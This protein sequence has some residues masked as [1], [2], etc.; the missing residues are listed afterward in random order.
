MR[1]FFFPLVLLL[2]LGNNGFATHFAGGDCY[3]DYVSATP[4]DNTRAR[5]AVH[6][7]FYRDIQGAA[8]NATSITAGMYDASPTS[9]AGVLE[10][11]RTV[12]QYS[13]QFLNQYSPGCF[14][15][16]P[17]GYERVE[18]IDTVDLLTT[19]GYFFSTSN[20][21]RNG[22]QIQ[23]ISQ[24]GPFSIVLSTYVPPR[25]SFDNNSPR[26][27][28]IPVPYACVGK[29]YVFNHDGFDPDGDSL[30]FNIVWPYGQG[31]TYRATGNVGEGGIPN[32]NVTT[33][34]LAQRVHFPTR[35][36][37]PGNNTG[38]SGYYTPVTYQG[39]Y[40]FPSNQVPA[41]LPDTLKMNGST[42][43]FSF[44]PTNQGGFV[45][46]I[47]CLE[48]RV[49]RINNVT[50]YLGSTRRDL[51]FFFDASCTGNT[52]PQIFV[53]D[54][55]TLN[56]GDSLILDANAIDFNPAKN[57]VTMGVTGDIIGTGIG[58]ATYTSTS[59]IGQATLSLRW[60]A[61]CSY[62]RTSPYILIITSNDSLCATTQKS[63]YI[64]VLPEDIISKPTNLIVIQN[65]TNIL[66]SWKNNY[67][68]GI[69]FSCFS[70]FKKEGNSNF[71]LL[72]NISNLNLN[73]F[74]DIL[75]KVN[76]QTISYCVIGKNNCNIYGLSSDTITIIPTWSNQ[77]QKVNYQAVALA[78]N[79][80]PV[81]NQAIILRLS[82]VDSS[83]TG[84]V[85]YTETHQ[86]TTDGAGQFSVFL[87][88]GTANL[89][90]FSNIFWG[91]GNDKFLKAEADVTGGT[92]YM[93]MG[94]SQIVSVPYAI[95]AGSL[96]EGATITGANGSQY[97]LTVGSGGPTWNLSNS[98]GIFNCGQTLFYSGEY[99]PTVLI[100]SK[101]WLAK[102]LNVGIM[103]SAAYDQY[104]NQVIEKY[105]YNSDTSNCRTYG[106][107]YQ[108]AE[109]VNYLNGA[110]NTSSPNPPFNGNIQGICP[111]SWH[112][113]SDIEWGNLEM[114]L[115][116]AGVAGGALKSTINLWNVPNNG[117]N[118]SSGF[119]AL[120]GGYSGKNINW[121]YNTKGDA[122]YIWSSSEISNT[123]ANVLRLIT[124]D[125][126]SRRNSIGK[127][128]GASVRC[129]KD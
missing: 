56:V 58:Q 92:N 4:G 72:K 37:L 80:Q 54:T 51:Q 121:N 87:G 45:V 48:Y 77:T 2:F 5:Y 47:E 55:F 65:D 44:N 119:S 18:F 67:L 98:T 113:P 118:N 127:D 73:Q 1:L 129:L 23:N 41:I 9:V 69:N 38:V 21:A 124:N 63:V 116:G 53:T 35:P 59:A 24:A 120:P 36:P 8:F 57:R 16:S 97:T 64:K 102:N 19:R 30:V 62:A 117:A 25:N 107:L 125:S 99:Y 11:L 70:I 39:A 61:T 105:C 83:A 20:S 78:A 112:L 126:F 74:T 12:P 123:S 114:F 82:I 66:I 94:T 52:A 108:W 6:Y 71:T 68:S 15:K 34:P 88:G 42:G 13:R 27:R 85:L 50:T 109:A 29:K 96:M 3:Y 100:N 31:G 76:F 84:T 7:I 32:F 111:F 91:N 101:C 22:G 81:K 33:L 103:N 26:F 60:K 28:A 89:G 86:P 90:S 17:I 104:D 115:G 95:V 46:A 106:G 110:S 122:T 49:D 75:P 14:Y 79:G 43:E 93:L 40:S 128:L 10:V